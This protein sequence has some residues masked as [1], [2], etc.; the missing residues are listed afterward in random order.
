RRPTPDCTRVSVTAGAARVS[1]CCTSPVT[2]TARERRGGVAAAGAGV[3]RTGSDADRS[4]ELDAAGATGA[5]VART[6]SN[7]DRSSEL[8]AAGAGGGDGTDGDRS[9]E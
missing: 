9:R 5:G 4:S 3:A 2:R 6:G 8:D 7:A 1:R